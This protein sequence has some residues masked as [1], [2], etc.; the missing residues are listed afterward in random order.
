[1][2]LATDDDTLQFSFASD[3]VELVVLTR[4][5]VFLQ[6]MREAVGAARR[7]WHVL[8]AEKVSDLLV[9]GEVGIVVLDVATMSQAANV[10]VA[11]I[12]RQFP[13]LVVVAGS[14]DA[15]L[16]LAGLISAGTVYRFIHKPVSPGRARLFAEAAV[17][18][19]GEQRLR[20]V[21][22]ERHVPRRNYL[23]LGAA[24][25]VLAVI[26][27]M[28]WTLR[29]GSPQQSAALASVEAGG[30]S[31]H[32]A[33]L[34]RAAAALAAD[35]LTAPAGDNALELYLQASAQSPADPLARAGLADV[36][37]RLL[38]RAE[39]ALLA[40]RLNEAEAAIETARWAGAESGR[41]AFLRAQL[42][43][44]KDQVRSAQAA[45]R[46]RAAGKP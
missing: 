36:R 39:N 43:K 28:V 22:P 29:G 31:L 6:T 38:A 13:E 41:I 1:M 7:L 11:Q 33:L 30:T 35:R 44:L 34:S 14:R 23:G 24:A 32:A 40:E 5:E 27:G 17:R 9:A 10:F 20:S 8:S 26:G 19:Y 25:V 18:K 4:D 45:A 21:V 3:I 37:D 42:A 46:S 2:A 12:K 15:E 16:A